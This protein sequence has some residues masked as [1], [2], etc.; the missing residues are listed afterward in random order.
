MTGVNSTD[1]STGGGPD[2]RAEPNV[3]EIQSLGS[4]FSTESV[5]GH[6][7]HL[8]ATEIYPVSGSRDPGGNSVFGA[9][10]PF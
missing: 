6:V 7:F 3:L 9:Q 4:G 2:R 10:V 8:P 1:I 5:Q